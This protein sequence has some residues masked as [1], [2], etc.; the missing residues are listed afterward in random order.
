[1][2]MYIIGRV[3]YPFLPTS[4]LYKFKRLYRS[5]RE[6]LRLPTHPCVNMNFSVNSIN[7]FSYPFVMIARC[8]VKVLSRNYTQQAIKYNKEYEL[9]QEQKEAIIGIILGDGYLERG[10]PTFNTRFRIEHAYPDQENYVLCL[11]NIFLNLMKSQPKIVIRKP[12]PL[13]G[14]IHKSIYIRTLRFPCLNKYHDLF[15]KDN[16]KIIPNNIEE[17]LTYRGLAHLIMCDGYFSTI[18]GVIFIC[19]ENYTKQE[20]ELLIKALGSSLGIK[21]SLNKRISS[22]GVTN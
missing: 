7:N 2:F 3:R 20:Q 9:N 5:G 1:M 10:K 19:T 15:I 11:Y 4:K 14:N 12:H 13:T 21:A 22:R 18:Q 16:L 17:L 8:N 6:S